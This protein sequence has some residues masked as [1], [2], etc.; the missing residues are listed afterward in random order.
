M[1]V[2][3]YV[4]YDNA[5]YIWE[6]SKNK[7][8]SK[9]TGKGLSEANYTQ[10]EKTKLAG[11]AAGAEVN[12][13]ADWDASTGDAAILNKPENLVQDANYVHTDNNYTSTEKTKLSGIASGA[14]VNVQ[15]DWNVTS[16]SSDAYIKNKPTIPTK[17]TDLTNDGNFVQDASYVHTDSNFTSAEKTKLS[18]IAT[19]AEANVQADW[20]ETTTT[21]DAYIKNKPTGLSDFTNDGNFVADASYVHTDNNY[22]TTEKNKLSGIA[23]G[24]E[25][26][27]QSNWNE[28][29]SSSDAY[30]KNK[31]TK[32]TDFTNDGNFV[33]D[34]NYSHITIDNSMSDSSV[35]PVANSIVKAYVDAAVGAAVGVAFVIVE[36]LPSTGSASTIYLVPNSG[37]NPNSYDE[38]I[39]IT[40]SG[41]GRFEK[42]GTTDIDLSGYQLSSE[43]VPLTVAE[44]DAICV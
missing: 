30:I 7:F 31:P 11:I 4:D 10:T 3:K 12:V 6:K 21:D 14:E 36:S 8:V 2:K 27:V 1:S 25:V 22:T 19:G 24:A 41:T 28:S 29:S 43:L 18:G 15:S 42:I 33:Q 32:L 40:V 34:A 17:L 9:E 23:A 35:N 37:S 26:N 44:I 20:N 39:W 5:A 38:Y 13:N 16:S